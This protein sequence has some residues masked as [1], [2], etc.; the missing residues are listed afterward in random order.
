MEIKKKVTSTVKTLSEKLEKHAQDGVI[1]GVPQV[2]DCRDPDFV[3]KYLIPA[4]QSSLFLVWP[5][6]FRGLIETTQ[7]EAPLK[8]YAKQCINATAMPT[9]ILE[10]RDA[11][12]G[13]RTL[14]RA[15]AETLYVS[16]TCWTC[17]IACIFTTSTL[18]SVS[19]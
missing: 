13:T 12:H 4:V 14:G 18:T 8:A 16:D 19:G 17:L 9:V 11:L 15:D 3:D 5:T 10:V 2:K 7:P 6:L 1:A